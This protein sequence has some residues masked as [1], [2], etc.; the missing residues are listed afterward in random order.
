MGGA[1]VLVLQ[2]GAADSD[3][4]EDGLEGGAGAAPAAELLAGLAAEAAE[5]Q[6]QVGVLEGLLEDQALE[7]LAGLLDGALQ[8]SGQA[9]VLGGQGQVELQFGTQVESASLGLDLVQADGRLALRGGAQGEASWRR[10]LAMR[11]S[12]S[13]S[14]FPSTARTDL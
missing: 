8:G 1:C 7:A 13:P 3:G 4:A 12:Y 11:I 2:A 5:D 14:P 6:L 10:K 9:L